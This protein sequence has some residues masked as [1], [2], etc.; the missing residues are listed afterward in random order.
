VERDA[1]IEKNRLLIF[2]TTLDGGFGRKLDLDAGATL[3]LARLEQAAIAATNIAA[4]AAA[5]KSEKNAKDS[6]DGGRVESGDSPGETRHKK[7][8]TFFRRKHHNNSQ[9]TTNG[10]AATRTPRP[11]TGP[12]LAV[13]DAEAHA[14]TPSADSNAQGKP[15]GAGAEDEEGGVK[16]TI[17]LSALDAEGRPAFGA[18]NEQT[19]YLHVVRVGTPPVRPEAAEGAEEGESEEEDTRPWVVKVVKREATVSLCWSLSFRNKS[20]YSLRMFIF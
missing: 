19:T 1:E 12:A 8:L 3:E 11:V 10:A 4:A 2:E 18:R 20:F 5:A 15:K 9:S 13:V 14:P 16:V 7:R 17:R 6:A